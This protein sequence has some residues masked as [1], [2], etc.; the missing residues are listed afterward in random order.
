VLTLQAEGRLNKSQL[1][2]RGDISYDRL[3]EVLPSM[4]QDRVVKEYREGNQLIYELD[5]AGV[6]LA[7]LLKDAKS[8]TRS[9]ELKGRL[10]GQLL[11]KLSELKR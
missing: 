8:L 7:S 5:N 6:L 10:P 4:V 3:H 11:R 2:R 9:L 1:A